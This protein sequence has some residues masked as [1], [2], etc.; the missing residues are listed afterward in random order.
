MFKKKPLPEL[1]HISEE[2][3]FINIPLRIVGKINLEGHYKIWAEALFHGELV[4][5]T[6]ELAKNISSAPITG[7]TTY[8]FLKDSIRFGYS[9]DTGVIDVSNISKGSHEIY[10]SYTFK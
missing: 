10:L 7:D 2:E 1:S 5:L 9:Y 3:G 6:I 8:L 4:S